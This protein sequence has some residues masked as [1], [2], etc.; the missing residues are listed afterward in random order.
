M[1]SLFRLFVVLG[2]VLTAGCSTTP[3]T[4]Y[5]SLMP[6]PAGTSAQG[7]GQQQGAG[8]YAIDVQ[9]VQ[10]PEQ[11]DRL[12][13]VVTDPSSTQVT[14]LNGY[15]WAS[16][17]ADEIRRALSDDLSRTLGV[18]DVS[19]VA[20]PA[21]MPVW[22]VSLQVQRFQ[23]FYE[24]RAVMDVVWQLE[25]RNFPGKRGRICRAEIQV[26]VGQGMSSLV[27]GHQQVVQRLSQMIAGQIRGA[28]LDTAIP[29]ITPKGCT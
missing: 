26:P 20:T 12:Q 14:P 19:G 10:L 8:G 28:A 15:L 23:S 2:A 6:P 5:Y 9:A 4:Y 1:R 13:I 7:S 24:E 25:P 22:A 21:S 17:L 16:P 29:G 27:A 3:P 18:L 11:V